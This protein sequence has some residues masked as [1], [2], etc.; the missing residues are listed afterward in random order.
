[1]YKSPIEIKLDDIISN[2]VEK[3]DE[4]MV[5]CVQQVGVDVDKDQLLKALE[6]DRSQYEKGYAD[7]QADAVRHGHL[8]K[9]LNS[10][11]CSKCEAILPDVGYRLNY[12]YC[13]KCGAKLDEVET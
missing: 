10:Y 9:C 11:V 12:C 6:H 1:M 2:V 3:T 5:R 4:Y 13:P 7:G 8:I